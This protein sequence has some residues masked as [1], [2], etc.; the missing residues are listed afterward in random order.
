MTE[1]ALRRQAARAGHD[2]KIAFARVKE[3]IRIWNNG[4]ART[5]GN[6][7]VYTD[8]ADATVD[9]MRSVSYTHLTLPTN[10]EV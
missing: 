6:Y 5:F 4:E 3:C 10:R 7:M 2:F 1:P 8:A 9:K